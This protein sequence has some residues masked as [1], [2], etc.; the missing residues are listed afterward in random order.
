MSKVSFLLVIPF[1]L[2]P[3]LSV[4]TAQE[5]ERVLIEKSELT[6]SQ[7][8]KLKGHEI[9]QEVSQWAGVGKEVGEAV[10]AGLGAVVDQADRFGT[11]KVGTFT[12]ILIAWKIIGRDFTNIVFGSLGW[13]I[14]LCIFIWSYRRMALPRRIVT[15]DESSGKDKVKEWI[16]VNVVESGRNNDH[17]VGVKLFHAGIFLIA[18]GIA[19]ALVFP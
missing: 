7:L 1:L 4:A 14:F 15:K 3:A 9:V 5:P 8:S 12:L 2:G 16:V 13:I 17:L 6:K 11:T 18:T 10:D 19:A